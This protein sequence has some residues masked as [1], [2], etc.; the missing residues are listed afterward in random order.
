MPYVHKFFELIIQIFSTT[1]SPEC[2]HTL[3][4][5][6][7]NLSQVILKASQC[8][9]LVGDKINMI[10]SALIV[11]DECDV[12]IHLSLNIKGATYGRMN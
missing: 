10:V 9:R 2:F 1:I 3:V 8:I 6:V 4:E 7:L 5:S 12:R 11:V